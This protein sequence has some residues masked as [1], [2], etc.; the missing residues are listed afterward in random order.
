MKI[1]IR[2]EREYWDT[3]IEAERLSSASRSGV[4]TEDGKR[5]LGALSHVV[6]QYELRK[7]T[8]VR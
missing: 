5:T 1:V 7:A 8:N 2:N 6:T 3:R 4:L